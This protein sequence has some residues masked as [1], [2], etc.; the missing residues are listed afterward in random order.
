MEKQTNFRLCKGITAIILA[1][2]LFCIPL[3]SAGFWNSTDKAIGYWKMDKGTG[4]LAEEQLF[5]INNLT[6][7]AT[8]GDTLRFDAFGKINSALGYFNQTKKVANISNIAQYNIQYYYNA[9]ISFWYKSG[10]ITDGLGIIGKL[11]GTSRG[12]FFVDQGLEARFFMIDGYPA[13]YFMALFPNVF[14]SN[15]DWKH[16]VITYN[17]TGA[18]MGVILYVNGIAVPQVGSVDAGGLTNTS[19][20]AMSLMMGNQAGGNFPCNCSLDEIGFWNRTLS[21]TEAGQLYN[22]GNG[23][24]PGVTLNSPSANSN[25]FV[26]LPITFNCSSILPGAVTFSNITLNLDNQVN[27]TTTISSLQTSFTLPSGQHNFSCS[28]RDTANVQYNSSLALFNV[29]NIVEIA[30]SYNVATVETS[31][32]TFSINV[33]Y[34]S[35][36]YTSLSAYLHYNNT[37]YSGSSSG[38]GNNKTFTRTIQIPTIGAAEN[39]TFYWRI[40]LTNSSGVNL[41]NSTFHNQS[42]SKIAFGPCSGTLT[43]PVLNFTAWNETSL[44]QVPSY[45]FAGTFEIW[46]SSGLASSTVSF[47]NITGIN[48]T[49]LCIGSHTSYIINAN[50][51]YSANGYAPRSY[52]LRSAT[53]N[54][55]TN[56]ISMYLLDSNKATAI[57]VNVQNNYLTN[58]K[59]HLV[60]VLRYY[61]GY[62]AY[63][64]VETAKTDDFGNAVIQ[65]EEENVDYRIQIENATGYQIYS[66]N[67]MRII[68]TGT[69]CTLSFITG[70]TEHIVKDLIDFSNV[71]YTLL[72]NNNTGYVTFEYSDGTGM[73]QS[74]RMLVVQQHNYGETTVCDNTISGSSGVS[75]CLIGSNATGQYSARVYRTASPAKYFADLSIYLSN[76]W[77]T[78]GTEGLVWM[79]LFTIVMFFTGLAIGPAAAGI[80]TVVSVL[81]MM[82]TG[83]VYMPL[84]VVI[85]IIIV[86]VIFIAKMRS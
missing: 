79:L 55:I 10:T 46:K 7:Q 48:S 66:S 59:N 37:D 64:L 11:D 6:L 22:N 53:V 75:S 45:T 70:V 30:Q 63:Y 61:P 42:I 8:A 36:Y 15:T 56:N 14:T 29:S 18:S 44:L 5:G 3:V 85:S 86:V 34:D 49:V 28:A 31:M 21:S 4:T 35:S 40:E 74:M 38:S 43:I 51:D 80:M 52:Y 16:Y 19:N 47:I 24:V 57:I 69:P 71:Q 68:C 33:S 26:V 78:F 73:T 20:N 82:A 39:K 23:L 67:S 13:N 1:L 27:L 60:K 72:W 12:W 54:N 9:S 41:F 32:E 17:G 25:N 76:T 65:A 58:L 83:I 84:V 62:G 50:I 81:F 2:A 77:Q